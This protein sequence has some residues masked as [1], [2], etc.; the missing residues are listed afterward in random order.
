MKNQKEEIQNFMPTKKLGQNFLINH[1]F[2]NKICDAADFSH[3]DIAIEVGPGYGVLTEQILEKVKYLYAIEKDR[4]LFS[5]LEKKFTGFKN[6]KLINGDILKTDIRKLTGKNSI[7]F[8]SNLPYNITSP[9]LSIL[10]ENREIFSNIVIMVQ[11]E[12][13]ERIASGPNTRIY[14]SLSVISQT[15]FDIKKICFVPSSAFKPRP[16]VDS[17]VLK[18]VPVTGFSKKISDSSI[19][20]NVVQSSFSSK[21]KMI[22][23]S[24][25]SSFEKEEIEIC[26]KKS[27]IDGKRRAETLGLE[28]FIEL[29]NNFFQLQ[30][31]IN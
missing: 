3:D 1:S 2:V 29:S 9:V 23:N 10:L 21:R 25:K 15:Y 31:S 5:L 6:I 17:V 12:V 13:G 27:G 28:E 18:L 7:K 20:K 30:Q 26:L 19:H 8:I 22:S 16:K 4:N 24:L 14:G 11:K